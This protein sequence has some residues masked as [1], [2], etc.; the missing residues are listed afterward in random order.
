MSADI[1]IIWRSV[2]FREED[3]VAVYTR[4]YSDE[5]VKI[6]EVNAKNKTIREWWCNKSDCPYDSHI[7]D[8][9][10]DMRRVK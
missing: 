1:N 9:A 3:I 6:V 7:A 4:G 5:T 2:K 10:Y 8:G